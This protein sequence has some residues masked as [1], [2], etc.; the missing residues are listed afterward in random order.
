MIF[1]KIQNDKSGQKVRKN[2]QKVRTKLMGESNRTTTQIIAVCF[3]FRLASPEAIPPFLPFSLTSLGLRL[4]LGIRFSAF[5]IKSPY[6]L[7]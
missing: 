3:F 7:A 5:G 2:A 6:C 1:V 4:L